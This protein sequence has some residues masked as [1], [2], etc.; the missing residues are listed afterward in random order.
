MTTDKTIR[1][2]A[3]VVYGVDGLPALYIELVLSKKMR[4]SEAI[5]E[6]LTETP[7]PAQVKH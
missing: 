4:L 6:F 7:Y 1:E 5:R 2:T 3:Q